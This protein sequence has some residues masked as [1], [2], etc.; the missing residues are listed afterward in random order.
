MTTWEEAEDLH[1]RFPT[2]LAWGQAGFRGGGN[3][4]TYKR[5]RAKEKAARSVKADGTPTPD[6]NPTTGGTASLTVKKVG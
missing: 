1:H 6:G 2:H 3:V 5:T 4:R